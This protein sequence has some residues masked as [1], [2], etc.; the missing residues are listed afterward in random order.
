M[1]E[2]EKKGLFDIDLENLNTDSTEQV[3]SSIFQDEIE[4]AEKEDKKEDLENGED[5]KETKKTKDDKEE[6]VDSSFF[7]NN[8]NSLNDTEDTTSIND[9]PVDNSSSPLQLLANTLR[10]GGVID[11]SEDFK[12]ESTEELLDAIR[13]TI[14]KNELADLTDEQ[15]EYVEAIRVGIP[16]KEVETNINNRKILDGITEESIASDENENL[17]KILITQEF[18]AQGI[19][20]SKAVKLADRSIELGEDVED[21]KEAYNSLKTIESNRIAKE[22]ENKKKQ[23]IEAKKAAETKLSKLKDKILNTEEFIPG[24]KPNATTKETVFKNMTKVVG[25]DDKGNGINAIMKARLEDPEAF[26]TIESYLFTLTKGFKDFSTFK[27]SVKSDA[28]KDLDKALKTNN[29]G[30]G[31]PKEIQSSTSKG[32]FAALDQFNKK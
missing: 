21:A 8:D 23:E 11:V 32:L 18:I 10:T 29:S 27:R 30:G 9:S 1:G 5:S 13:D 14:S 7:E 4:T 17:R 25:Y 20:E 31:T 6:S 19:A 12:I 22:I 24:L 26:E 3:D 28:I 16:Q 15:K 2:E